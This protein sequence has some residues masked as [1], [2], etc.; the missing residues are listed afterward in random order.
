MSNI[1]K[2][3][4][5]IVIQNKE[6]GLYISSTPSSAAKKAVSKLCASNKSKKVEFYIREITR[7]SKKK[8]Y[9]PYIGYLEKLKIPIKLKEYIIKYNPVAKLKKKS[10]VKKVEM[11]GGTK[12][13]FKNYIGKYTSMWAKI[14]IETK[15]K[16]DLFKK[17][18]VI[19]LV[20]DE[21]K[22]KKERNSKLETEDF[23]SFLYNLSKSTP[24]LTRNSNI[25]DFRF[26]ND[27]TYDILQN[28]LEEQRPK[29]IKIFEDL[30]I[31]YDIKIYIDVPYVDDRNPE[32]EPT[33]ER[34]EYL[35]Y[36]PNK[37]LKYL[38][39]ALKS[40]GIDK[41]LNLFSRFLES[42]PITLPIISVGSGNAYFEFLISHMHKREI[43]CVDPTPR[44]FRINARTNSHHTVFIE[45]KFSTVDQLISS[46]NHNQYKNCLLILNWPNPQNK[47][48]QIMY[49]FDA[50]IK[51]KPNG[52]FIIFDSNGLS[53]SNK[54]IQLLRSIKNTIN[55][56]TELSYKL[57]EKEEHFQRSNKYGIDI[58][59]NFVVAF[60]IR[61]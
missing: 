14:V 49:D 48:G 9:G 36:K 20:F 4:F 61:T 55:F 13:I 57:L 40:I 1:S 50:I 8:T 43:T 45:P 35:E 2:R 10:T 59:Y 39:I 38:N 5:T 29:I 47:N 53:G 16:K 31:Q 52:F 60:Y 28:F 21:E 56:N 27:I 51:L 3:H 33:Y 34:I 41:C 6:R 26:R 37:M 24:E 19:R 30:E 17:F 18:D 44:S 23:K 46:N 25:F 54:M 7:D 42:F 58:D 32:S 11:K 15:E 22:F 12:E